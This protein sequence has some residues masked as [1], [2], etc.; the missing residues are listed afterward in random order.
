MYQRLV[1]VNNLLQIDTL[2]CVM[3][4]SSVLIELFVCFDDVFDGC[5]GLDDRRA[6][7]AAGKVATIGDEVNV[8]IKIALY[9][10]Q[11]LTNLS[12]VLVLER[13]VD[14]QVVVAP[15]EVRGGSW[16]LTC[17]CGTGD[18]LQATRRLEYRWQNIRDWPH[19]EPL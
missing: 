5:L 16:L 15:R 10:L 14:A 3:S 13:L 6:E 1:G 17:S 8:G 9:L 11:R 4:E 7:N 18:G 19:A 12:N 2:I